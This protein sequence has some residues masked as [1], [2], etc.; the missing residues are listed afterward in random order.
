[1]HWE[2]D[3]QSVHKD[4]GDPSIRCSRDNTCST[5]PISVEPVTVSSRHPS[6]SSKGL[7]ITPLWYLNRTA[8]KDWKERAIKVTMLGNSP[9]PMQVKYLPDAKSRIVSIKPVNFVRSWHCR[10]II[11]I[12]AWK[13]K[14][15]RSNFSRKPETLRQFRKMK[16]KL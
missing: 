16:Q 8:D 1:M 12:T 9:I 4:K 7:C 13:G 3:C 14:Q 15:S 6:E 5:T 10:V 2:W 11:S